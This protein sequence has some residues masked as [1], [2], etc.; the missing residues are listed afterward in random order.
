MSTCKSHPPYFPLPFVHVA[1]GYDYDKMSDLVSAQ[2]GHSDFLSRTDLFST[3]IE[4][5]NPN[6]FK[7]EKR[8]SN[9]YCHNFTST[10]WSEMSKIQGVGELAISTKWISTFSLENIFLIVQGF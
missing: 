5:S 6:L 3:R 9:W 7:L 4:P 8:N 1:I 10:L 2:P